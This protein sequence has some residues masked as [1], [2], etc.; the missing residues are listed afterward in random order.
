MQDLF[1]QPIAPGALTEKIRRKPGRGHPWKGGYAAQPGSGPEG[2]TCKTCRHRVRVGG[3]TR[4]YPKCQLMQHAWTCGPGS[5]IRVRTAACS[6]WE[7][8][9]D[10]PI[11]L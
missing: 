1:G 2:E 6:R 5:D 10:A 11:D 4:S 3:G 8:R 9:I 7:S